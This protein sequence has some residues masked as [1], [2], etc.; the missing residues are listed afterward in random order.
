MHMYTVEFALWALFGAFVVE[1]IDFITSSKAARGWPWERPDAPRL[2]AYL[3]ATFVRLMTGCIAGVTLGASDQ[4][5]SP[6]MAVIV[7]ASTVLALERITGAVVV[8][9]M[10]VNFESAGPVTIRP[11]EHGTR[12]T[13]S[14]SGFLSADDK[15]FPESSQKGEHEAPERGQ[16]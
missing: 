14:V 1:S 10:A 12:F 9:P 5:V 11:S 7:G 8:S 13:D 2:G 16:G 15:S 3:V 4:I 6:L